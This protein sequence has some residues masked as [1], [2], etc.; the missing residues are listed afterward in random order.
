M[1]RRTIFLGN[2]KFWA[3]TIIVIIFIFWVIFGGRRDLQP[4]GLA[5]LFAPQSPRQDP[6]PG[7]PVH[8]DPGDVQPG[9]V[10]IS[11]RTP[12]RLEREGNVTPPGGASPRGLVRRDSIEGLPPPPPRRFR[13]I[14]EELTCVAFEEILGRRVQVNVRPNFL[15]NPETGRNLEY[16]CYDPETGIA[17]EYDGGQHRVFTPRFHASQ[18]DFERQMR[19]DKL[20]NDLSVENNIT[21]IR[22]ADIVDVCDPDERDPSGFRYNPRINRIE[23]GRRIRAYLESRLGSA[24]AGLQE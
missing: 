7:S 12:M 16:D 3:I 19:L 18:E 13:S 9:N 1:Q 5:P 8:N 4:I 14:G 24:M 10:S 6:L 11:P 21:L 22:V 17:I 23:R 2:W 20:K 15:R